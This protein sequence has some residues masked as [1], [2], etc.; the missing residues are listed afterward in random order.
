MKR[1]HAELAITMRNWRKHRRIHVANNLARGKVGQDPFQVD[2][3][4]DD[5]P[6]RFRKR[7]AY[8]CGNSQCYLCNHGKFPK[9][10]PTC[11]EILSA[12]SLKEQIQELR[13]RKSQ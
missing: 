9:R 11:Q 2:C 4:C 3:A 7:D 5:Q 10:I 12:L 6:G 13:E 1:W 8:D